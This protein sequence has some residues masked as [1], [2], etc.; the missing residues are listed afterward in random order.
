MWALRARVRSDCSK[1]SAR[2]PRGGALVI[3]DLLAVGVGGAAGAV[4]RYLVYLLSTKYLGVAFPYGT[5]IVN[6]G[7]SFV[8]GV[9][10]ELMALHWNVAAPTR[11]LLVVGFLGAFTTFS[12]FSLDVA[13][14]YERS[15]LFLASVYILVS[16]V[17]SIGALFL[18]MLLVR[19]ID[20][21]WPGGL[22]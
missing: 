10:I 22:S 11:L 21:A 20:S 16:V 17:C 19:R 7:G 1:P 15:A 8:M 12:T 4:S 5:V 13:V 6:V 2:G 14:L 9:L 3:K 18:G